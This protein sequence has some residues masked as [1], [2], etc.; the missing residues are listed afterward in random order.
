MKTAQIQQ[1]AIPPNGP[2]F[3]LISKPVPALHHM[4]IIRIKTFLLCWCFHATAT[5][6]HG[7]HR[8]KHPAKAPIT[9]TRRC[10][11]AV[12]ARR[13]LSGPARRAGRRCAQQTAVTGI[14]A[15][16][17][18]LKQRRGRRARRDEPPAAG[19]DESARVGAP[20]GRGC[21]R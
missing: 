13:A 3:V 16:Q 10:T 20:L 6:P 11:T 4:I 2:H 17:R 1:H 12:D 18:R 8:R 21:G 9:S 14:R 7:S 15:A 5:F 19:Y